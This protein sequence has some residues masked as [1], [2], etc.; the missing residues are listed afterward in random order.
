[1]RSSAVQTAGMACPRRRDMT[2]RG[3]KERAST[4]R[5]LL[6]VHGGEASHR[7]TGSDFVLE[8][9]RVQN[10]RFDGALPLE[11]RLAGERSP[12][13]RGR[14]ATAA[15]RPTHRGLRCTAPSPRAPHLKV[16][17]A[18]PIRLMDRLSRA[19]SQNPTIVAIREGG[20]RGGSYR[21]TAVS[22]AQA[23]P[24]FA[25]PETLRVQDRVGRCRRRWRLS[26]LWQR[27]AAVAVRASG[28]PLA[29]P[30][31]LNHPR[32][33]MCKPLCDD[34]AGG[35]AA[36]S[37]RARPRGVA[38]EGIARR[39][40]RPCRPANGRK[41]GPLRVASGCLLTCLE[42]GAVR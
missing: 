20:G 15:N 33:M 37:G 40:G 5:D 12:G 24:T 35:S 30:G 2:R 16:H 1:M 18:C 4:Q 17:Q 34:G 11:G 13:D 32:R 23:A 8:L 21:A 3:I 27:L 25:A 7:S 42:G 29:W 22:H 14:R 26:G 10:P 41:H 38:K 28:A 9:R 31:H 39:H 36:Q 19:S 6:G